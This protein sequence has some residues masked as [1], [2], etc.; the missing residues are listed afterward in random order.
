[1]GVNQIRADP[2]DAIAGKSEMKIR[3]QTVFSVA[4]R[5]RRMTVRD[6]ISGCWN[7]R[8]SLRR[9]Y[10]RMIVGSRVD[11]SRQSK[12]AHRAAYETFIGL[13]PPGLEICHHC[14]NRKCCNPEHLFAGT[15]QD[16]VD[17][18]E[19]KGRNRPPHGEASGT[20]RL[21]DAKVLS[22]RLLRQDGLTYTKIA[23]HFCVSKKTIRQAVKGNSWKHL[24]APSPTGG[25]E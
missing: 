15:R 16:N 11:G 18:R 7:W 25:E 22:A 6:E 3:G 17:D 24:A 20:A 9:G 23:A 19:A 2:L 5:I 12:S 14:D 21:T 1:L 4:D 13:I 8:G 10:G